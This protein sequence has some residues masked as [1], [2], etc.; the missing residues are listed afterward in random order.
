MTGKT[1]G[2]GSPLSPFVTGS[3]GRCPRCGKGRLF[4]GFLTVASKCGACGLDLGFAD[5]GDG[6]AVFVSLVGGLLVLGAALAVEI[7]FE[8][9]LWIYPIV[10]APF[11]LVVCIGLLRPFK[12][13][14]IAAQYVNRAEQ[15]RLEGP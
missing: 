7:A 1:G 14:L 9:P 13:F 12:G 8:P 3:L 6:P 4:S 2:G 5:A 10:F 15:G 11:A